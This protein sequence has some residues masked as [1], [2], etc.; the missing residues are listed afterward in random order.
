MIL[1]TLSSK[2]ASSF[3]WVLEGTFICLGKNKLI[4]AKLSYIFVDQTLKPTEN[5][6]TLHDPLCDIKIYTAYRISSNERRPLVNA[7][8]Y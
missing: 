6:E 7:V 2:E 3:A 5:S 1:L 8:L 4:Y